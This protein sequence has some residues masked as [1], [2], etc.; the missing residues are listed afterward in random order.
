MRHNA[1]F[2][3][4]AVALTLVACNK[5]NLPP[6]AATVRPVLVQ[7]LQ[8]ASTTPILYSG[9]V[10]ARHESDL[11]FRVPGKLVARLV[12]VG[13]RVER[14]KA[15]ARLDPADLQ[16]NAQ[17]AKAQLAAA[18]SDLNLADAEQVRYAALL[19]RKL[20]SPSVYDA[21]ATVYKA[22]RARRDQAKAQLAVID[23]QAE[24]S[25]LTAD[26]AGVVTAVLAEVGQV[27][28]AGQPVFK[29]ARPDEQEIVINIPEGRVAELRQA[30]AMTVTLWAKPELR[31]PAE[32][33]ELAPAADAATRTYAARIRLLAADPAV[34]LGMTAQVMVQPAASAGQLLVPL[35][36]VVEHGA[37]PAVWVVAD[38][39]AQRRPVTIGQYREEGAVLASGVQ[40]GELV[41]TVGAHKLVPGQ[42]VRPVMQESVSAGT[43][44]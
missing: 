16:L 20:I 36:A 4:L 42:A 27:V 19:E 3:L 9:E 10:R 17:A 22:A 14:G 25:T 6:P 8:A 43:R 2:A 39:K 41:V 32:L 1:V 38:G 12:D 37:G 24:Y 11:A 26:H 7:A 40:A 35:T 5:P 15:L 13:A 28:A 34:R 18:E 23:N 30:K 21:K 44:P 31:L 29:L 33:R